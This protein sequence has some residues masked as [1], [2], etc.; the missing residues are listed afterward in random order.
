M[1]PLRPGDVAPGL[2]LDDES[3][4]PVSL[5]RREGRT[6]LVFYRGDW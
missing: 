4:R 3:G 6:V 1:A 2:T 5:P